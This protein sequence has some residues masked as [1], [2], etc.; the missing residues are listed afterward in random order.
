MFNTLTWNIRGAAAKGVPLLIKDLVARHKI[1]CMALFETRVS[2]PKALK[3]ISKLGFDKSFVVDAEGFAGGIWILWKS[4]E[5]QLEVL[6]SHRQFVHTRVLSGSSQAAFLTFVY[7]SP[8]GV[9]R[10]ALW[11]SLENF[12]Q[13]IRSPWLVMGDFNAYLGADEKFGGAAANVSSMRRFRSCLSSSNLSDMGFKGPP[14]TW[15]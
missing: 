1:S 7:G 9:T 6:H 5:V 15:E 8:Q 11:E 3:I 2:G 14:Y 10:N 13:H 4:F 12:S